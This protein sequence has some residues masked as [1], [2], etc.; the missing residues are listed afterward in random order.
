[1]TDDREKELEDEIRYW[2]EKLE[3][4]WADEDRG[5]VWF[6]LAEER[7]EEI[8]RLQKKLA[9]FRAAL[10]WKSEIL[11]GWIVAGEDVDKRLNKALAWE[12]FGLTL[13]GYAEIIE[14]VHPTLTN[15]LK[16][17]LRSKNEVM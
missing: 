11:T 17:V 1:M 15:L 5:R 6:H 7:K 10:P 4:T 12:Q 9:E 13:N 16:E 8:E 3:D 2:R 14:S